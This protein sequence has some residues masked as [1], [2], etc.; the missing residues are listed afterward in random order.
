MENL[1]G[2]AR[3]P[4]ALVEFDCGSRST[5]RTRFSERER[6]AARFTAVVVFPTPPFWLTMEIVRAMSRPPGPA[7]R[8]ARVYH[9]VFSCMPENSFRAH[10]QLFPRE[11]VSLGTIIPRG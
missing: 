1:S 6:A 5:R 2:S 9:M 11:I 3:N 10:F 8:A 4:R 7:F